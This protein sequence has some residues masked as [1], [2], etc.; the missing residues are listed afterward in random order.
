MNFLKRYLSAIFSFC[1]LILG[2]ADA[3]SQTEYN[4]QVVDFHTQQP[5]SGARVTYGCDS[6]NY[7]QTDEDGR[8]ELMIDPEVTGTDGRPESDERIPGVVSVYSFL[9]QLLNQ[10]TADVSRKQLNDGSF[11]VNGKL[12]TVTALAGSEVSAGTP[13]SLKS[14]LSCDEILLEKEGYTSQSYSLHDGTVFELLDTAY[15]ELVFV[16]Q[17][18]HP[19]TFK[20]FQGDPLLHDWGETESIKFIYDFVHDTIYYFNSNK[21]QYHYYFAR[22]VLGYRLGVDVFNNEQYLNNPSRMFYMGTLNYYPYLEKYA[23]DFFPGDEIDCEGVGRLF[24]KIYATSYFDDDLFLLAN[25]LK[26][27]G[28]DQ[29]LMYQDEVIGNKNYVAMN[30]AEGFG[31]LKF[32]DT[33][34][35]EQVIAGRHDI[36]ILNSLP[37]N[38]KVV[39]GMITTAFQTPLCHL[40]VLSHN[41]QTPNMVLGDA[42][43]NPIFDSLLNKLVYLKVESDTFYIRSASI[44]EAEQ[45]W[46]VKEPHKLVKLELNTVAR[47]I[48]SLDTAGRRSVKS[49]GGKASNFAELVS[50][51][52]RQLGT[53]PLPESYFA[54][55]FHYYWEHLSQAGLHA[56]IDSMLTD[57]EFQTNSVYRSLKLEELRDSIIAWPVN[58]DLL[59]LVTEEI[60]QQGSFTRFRFRSSTNAEDIEGFNGAGLYDSQTGILDHS[61]RTIEKAITK[62]WASLWNQAAFEERDYF[63]IDHTTVAM[64]VLVHRGFPDEDANGVIVTENQY[65][66]YPAYTINAQYGEYSVVDPSGNTVPDIVL[67]YHLTGIQQM[68][69]SIEYIRRSNLTSAGS[70]TVMTDDEI[71]LLDDYCRLIVKHYRSIGYWGTLDIEFKLDSSIGAARKLYIKQ[72]RP[73]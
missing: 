17:I 68:D 10:Y 4:G 69:Q 16:N 55:P 39:S 47:G 6:V 70:K 63:K 71:R 41:R 43:T 15:A 59:Q 66:D 22:D 24:D 9:G 28:C 64:G 31:Y 26:W 46:A 33:K 35:N 56:Y 49:I 7:T 20:I 18:R 72:V 12:V 8:F 52:D 21:Y 58:P 36:V 42:E 45:F 62:V 30:V 48:V 14:G 23:V 67:I 40:N 3:F 2:D 19:E 11:V 61:S 1:L 51:Q 34:H 32:I 13:N 54:I 38:I 5:V 53:I 65:G 60:Q 37:L 57:D 27:A 73:Y 44:S 29:P 25:N 50:I